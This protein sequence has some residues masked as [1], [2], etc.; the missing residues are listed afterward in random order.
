VGKMHLYLGVYIQIYVVEIF[1]RKQR[2]LRVIG[3]V[4]FSNVKAV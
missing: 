2:L 4:V 1:Y 3:V